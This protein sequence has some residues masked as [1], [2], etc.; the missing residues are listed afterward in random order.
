MS[1]GHKLVAGLCRDY[2]GSL[3]KGLLGCIEGVLTTA[4][5]WFLIG[6]LL[7]WGSRSSCCSFIT[8]SEGGLSRGHVKGG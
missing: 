4:H 5:M 6:G 7:Y 3:V 8:S 1:H 2:I